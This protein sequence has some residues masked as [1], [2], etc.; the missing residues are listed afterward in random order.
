MWTTKISNDK[1]SKGTMDLCS[2]FFKQQE[3]EKMSAIWERANN[4]SELG[5]KVHSAA[6]VVEMV[7]ADLSDNAQSGASWAAVD[8]LTRISDEIDSEVSAVMSEGRKLE[9]RI[10]KL[11]AIIA[12]HELKK[13]KTKDID[14]DG[15]C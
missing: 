12:K 9:E 1:L 14:P 11:E 5:Y 6:M 8:M 10:Q 4:I 3:S 13:K 2:T 15:R 7:A